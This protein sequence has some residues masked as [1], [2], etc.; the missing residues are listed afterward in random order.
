[1]KRA[2]TLCCI[3]LYQTSLRDSPVF[4]LCLSSGHICLFFF[5]SVVC[6]RIRCLPF[7]HLTPTNKSSSPSSVSVFLSLCLFCICFIL[8]LSH[9]NKQYKW[10]LEK[11]SQD[12]QTFAATTTTSLQAEWPSW[13]QHRPP[14][15]STKVCRGPDILIALIAPVRPSDLNKPDCPLNHL[16]LTLPPAE[17]ARMPSYPK[18]CRW[19]CQNQ[20][21]ITSTIN[22]M[23]CDH[24]TYFWNTKFSSKMK[25]SNVWRL[26]KHSWQIGCLNCQPTHFLPSVKLCVK[27]ILSHNKTCV[28]TQPA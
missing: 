16:Q 6:F 7:L 4:N 19:G 3:F 28:G 17:V 2:D 11:R 5:P 23:K 12:S 25:L 24:L 9:L 8:P 13:E 21:S 20:C 26:E 27:H 15:A 14:V 10:N 18:L 22:V 1:M